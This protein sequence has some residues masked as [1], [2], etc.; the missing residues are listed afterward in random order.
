MVSQL[1]LEDK[2]N[3]FLNSLNEQEYA[4]FVRSR[5]VGVDN[6][7]G[8]SSLASEILESDNKQSMLQYI[9]HE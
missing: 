9:L 7:Y 5:K 1:G 8:K 3:V 4:E 6:K 2:E